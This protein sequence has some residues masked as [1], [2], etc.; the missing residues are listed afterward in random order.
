MSQRATSCCLY[1]HRSRPIDVSNNR[2]N[3]V[4]FYS[5][6][7][8]SFST[9]SSSHRLDLLSAASN[10]WVVMDLVYL[11][12]RRRLTGGEAPSLS[13]SGTPDCHQNR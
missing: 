11:S 13:A 10:P 6:F 12:S 8:P 9:F 4:Y 7:Y 5:K 2:T 1:K 3:T